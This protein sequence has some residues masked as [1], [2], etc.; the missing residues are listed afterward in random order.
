MTTV[1]HSNIVVEPHT[2]LNQIAKNRKKILNYN[3]FFKFVL[4]FIIFLIVIIIH[5][6][7]ISKQYT[8]INVIF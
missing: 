7:L 8:Y 3:F 2:V 4:F 6:V 1:I 5:N